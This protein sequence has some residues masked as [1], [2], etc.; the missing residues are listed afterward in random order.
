MDFTLP[1]THSFDT[2][3][4]AKATVD[5]VPNCRNKVTCADILALATRDVVKSLSQH[6]GPSECVRAR[7]NARTVLV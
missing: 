3:I 2:V 5:R 1:W 4:K 7:L 6:S